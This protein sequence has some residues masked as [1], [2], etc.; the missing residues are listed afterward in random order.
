MWLATQLVLGVFVMQWCTL[1][2]IG[3]SSSEFCQRAESITYH[4]ARANRCKCFPEPAR[5]SKCSVTRYTGGFLTS[6]SCTS[7]CTYCDPTKGVCGTVTVDAL[8]GRTQPPIFTVPT[9]YTTI[10]TYTWYYSKGRTGTVSYEHDAERGKHDV[11][12][13]SRSCKSCTSVKCGDNTTDLQ[14]DCTNLESGAVSSPCTGRLAG[15]LVSLNDTALNTSLAALTFLFWGCEQN[16]TI[17]STPVLPNAST[18]TS[19]TPQ[20]STPT[21]SKMPPAPTTA[22]APTMAAAAPATA[23]SPLTPPST[24]RKCGLLRLGL[25]CPLQGCG[26][27]GRILG[28]CKKDSSKT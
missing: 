22:D 17:A 5:C 27:I 25:F 6:A 16:T 26:W 19:T 4:N 21:T 18:P 13:N 7:G 20:A 24:N 9:S 10:L 11:Q 15:G 23:A 14:I 12:I 2:V 1:P 28:Q 3:Q 8:Y